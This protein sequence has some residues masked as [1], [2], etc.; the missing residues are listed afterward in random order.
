MDQVGLEKDTISL[1]V[2]LVNT[3]DKP[4]VLDADGLASFPFLNGP[5]DNLIITHLGEFSKIL[6]IDKMILL[7]DFIKI[8][9]NF[10]ANFKVLQ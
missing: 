6:N 7:N 4:I 5:L 8:V 2:K 3:I 9:K 1:V 10:L